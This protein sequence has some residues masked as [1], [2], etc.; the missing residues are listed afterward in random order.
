MGVGRAAGRL[1]EL[2]ERKR[3]A[4]TRNCA[5]PARSRRRSRSGTL[6][7][8]RRHRR[9]RASAAFRRGGD[10]E[11]RRMCDAR[12]ARDVAAL[13]RGCERAVDVARVRLRFERAQSSIVRRRCQDVLLAHKFDAAT[14]VRE[15]AAGRAAL[16]SVRPR[17]QDRPRSPAGVDHSH[18]SRASGSGALVHAL[19]VAAHHRARG[20]HAILPRALRADMGEPALR[21]QGRAVDRDRARVPMSPS[22]HN[23]SARYFMVQVPGSW[24]K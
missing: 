6:P 2:G 10:A 5:S 15:P 19:R 22:G 13:R 18:V 4:Q 23:V 12:S 21:A 9:D 8:R 17:E 16:S 7:Q 11:G 3:R 1:V 20:P 24:P 14:H